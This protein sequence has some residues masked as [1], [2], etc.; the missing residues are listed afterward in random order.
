MVMTWLRQSG[1]SLS[2]Q[3]RFSPS[4]RTFTMGFSG[5]D[6]RPGGSGV[7]LWIYGVE[8]REQEVSVS[9]G[10]ARHKTA[11]CSFRGTRF[12]LLDDTSRSLL[13]TCSPATNF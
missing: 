7:G 2:S 6:S 3:F 1:S 12:L 10:L 8:G 4:S 5:S 13:I 11:T 9:L